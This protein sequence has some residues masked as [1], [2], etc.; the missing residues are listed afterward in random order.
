MI[1]VSP[2]VLG[3]I[4]EALMLNSTER[5]TLFELA[6]PE[7]GA[8]TLQPR[9][10]DVLESF[11]TVRSLARRLWTATTEQEVLRI[12]REH[13]ITQFGP[14]AMATAVRNGDGVWNDVETGVTK[15]SRQWAAFY[16]LMRASWRR[17]IRDEIHCYPFLAQ[18]GEVITRF[19]HPPPSRDLAIR[20]GEL[21]HLLDFSDVD[22]LCAAVRSRNGFHCR[23]ETVYSERHF[24]PKEHR[25]LMSAIADIASLAIADAPPN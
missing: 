12:V 23:I 3:R 5:S 10:T 4:A 6:V 14:D 9:S 25:T 15:A 13:C 20:L 2:A 22:F 18:P 11:G 21:N 1:R 24:F 8:T 16:S 19:E 17:D 7:L